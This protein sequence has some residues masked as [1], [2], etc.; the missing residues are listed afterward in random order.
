MIV[1]SG[2]MRRLEAAEKIWDNSSEVTLWFKSRVSRWPEGMVLI[3]ASW[4]TKY[5]LERDLTI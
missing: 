3:R 4:V 5:R 1:E 2:L